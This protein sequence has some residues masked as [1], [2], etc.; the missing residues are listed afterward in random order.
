M[1]SYFAKTAGLKLFEEH[2]QRYKP[3][4]PLYETYRDDR[5]REKRR[6]VRY[7]G[8]FHTHI[9]KSYLVASVRFPRVYRSETLAFSSP[10]KSAP[11]TLTPVSVSA[12]SGSDG[13]SSSVRCA[14]PT[15][16]VPP[17]STHDLV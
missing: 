12:A 6:K 8:R 14:P 2:L 15:P 13:P 9:I 5:G 16:I 7:T 11:I 4:D 1:A 10:S 3:A 17:N